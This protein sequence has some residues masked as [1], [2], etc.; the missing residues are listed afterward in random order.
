MKDN[1]DVNNQKRRQF[2]RI[3][4]Y[5]VAGVFAFFLLLS[6]FIKDSGVVV[7]KGILFFGFFLT[8]YTAYLLS[9]TKYDFIKLYRILTFFLGFFITYVSLLISDISRA[10]HFLFVPIVLLIMLISSFK[11]AVSWGIVFLLFSVFSSQ[12][13][14][15]FQLD[16]REDFFKNQP[17]IL[18]IQ[19]YIVIIIA[20]YFSFVIL[21]FNN[22]FIKANSED[23]PVPLLDEINQEDFP[24]EDHFS[25]SENSSELTFE[26]LDKDKILY[27]KIV[28]FFEEKKPYKNPE[29]NIRKLAELL[30]S[31]STYV[32]RALNRVGNK[33]FNQLVNDYRIDQVKREIAGNLHQK[34][35]LEHI[36]TNAGFSQQ[37]TF[38]RIFKEYTGF[39]PS[40]YIENLDRSTNM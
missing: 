33:K 39:T 6:I 13:S 27:Q 21:Y 17:E 16:I 32:S 25:E 14:A 38:N 5:S 29:F 26:S 19:E 34:F 24:R 30:D 36:Y 35:T 3:F 8:I 9:K 28:Q 7:S 12:I 10:I 20:T 18:L 23:Q 1:F 4:F 11:K 2:G 37:S 40:E 31:N 22:E 15:Y